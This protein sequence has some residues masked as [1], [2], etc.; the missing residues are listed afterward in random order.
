M[1]SGAG[2]CTELQTSLERWYFPCLLGC[3]NV[4]LI[5]GFARPGGKAAK[6]NLESSNAGGGGSRALCSLSTLAISI[7]QFIS[8]ARD[9]DALT[10]PDDVCQNGHTLHRRRTKLE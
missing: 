7:N 5:F 8:I 1:R 4:N 10:T 9:V 6:I 2:G 3:A